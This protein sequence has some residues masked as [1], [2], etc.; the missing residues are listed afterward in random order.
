MPRSADPGLPDRIIDAAARLLAADGAGAVSARRVAREV[1]TSTMTVYTHFGG[2]DGV[3]RQVM[4]RGF[5]AFG[6][7][8]T[9]SR[10]TDDPVA[11][12]M[13]QG[14]GY[15]RFAIRHP[16]LYRVMFGAG[17]TAFKLGDPADFE[18]AMSTFLALLD[19]IK[20]CVDAGRWQVR[21]IATAGEAVWAAAHGHMTIELTGYFAALGRDPVRSFSE[22]LTRLSRGFGDEA[23]STAKSLANARRRA[24]RADRVHAR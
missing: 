2:M 4:R 3:R 16:D 24:T 11:D 7:E 9:L 21:D 19:R 17:L 5:A 1:G 13:T 23:S 20:A 8:L 6:A 22:I 15:R 14:W 18:A 10:V 12:W